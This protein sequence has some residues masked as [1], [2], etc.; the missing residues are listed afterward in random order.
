MDTIIEK[1]GI[2][3][4]FT[5]LGAGIISNVLWYFA[6]GGEYKIISLNKCKE[7]DIFIGLIICYICG[8]ILQE[9]SSFLDD[10]I[11]KFR[12][13]ARKNIL[14]NNKI[15]KNKTELKLYRKLAKKSLNKKNLYFSDEDN[16]TFYFIAKTYLERHSD[17]SKISRINSIYGM[18]R[19]VALASIIAIPFTVV[20]YILF[21]PKFL[22]F[23]ENIY[24]V[25]AFIVLEI[26]IS[27]L[28]DY[29]ASRFAK[30]EARAIVRYY[31]DEIKSK[32]KDK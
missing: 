29:R 10:K 19:S 8:L 16:E 11:F 13:N 25:I 4:I 7:I 14:K 5:V 27:V 21:M 18:S 26:M 22:L 24:S 30:Y 32:L 20:S 1:L 12:K 23:G 17:N 31:Y 2:Y 3:E 6:S 15:I 9:V 28:F